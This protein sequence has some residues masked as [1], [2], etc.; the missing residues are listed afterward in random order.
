M[1]MMQTERWSDGQLYTIMCQETHG[2]KFV[3]HIRGELCRTLDDFF[4]EVSSA[5]RFPHYFGWNWAAFDECMTDL[6]W[7]SFQG[8][9]IVI[10]QFHKTFSGEKPSRACREDLVR[11]LAYAAEYWESNRVPITVV[12]NR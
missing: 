2:G 8:L 4:R 10:D 7:L 5:M 12:L 6:E 1:E 3:V 11:H 9:F